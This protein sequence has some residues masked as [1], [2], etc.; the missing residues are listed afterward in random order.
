MASYRIEWKSSAE[1]DLRNIDKQDIPRLIEAVE[2]LANNPFS[3]QCRKLEG[4]ESSYR[5]R[6]GN[7]RI[8]YQVDTT[9][10][11]VTIFHVRHRK[12]VYR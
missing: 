6:V 4:V 7:Y 11:S 2:E 12:D 3:H 1:R 8:I 9:K 10:K 5:I